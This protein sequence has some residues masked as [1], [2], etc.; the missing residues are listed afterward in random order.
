M[1]FY[2]PIAGYES[3]YLVS[4]NGDVYSI[5]RRRLL[6]PQITDKGYLTVEL[7]DSYSRRSVKIHRLVAETFIE[8]PSG[9][10]EINHK[11]GDKAD[12]RVENLEWCS[13]SENILHAYATGLR[14]PN[15][16]R[17]YKKRGDVVEH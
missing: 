2:V 17:R 1:S 8:N 7:W 12:N 4:K 14:K 5:R 10:K 6:K 16:G 11:N 9:L 13:R 15:R 3:K